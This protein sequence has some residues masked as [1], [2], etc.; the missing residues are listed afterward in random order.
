MLDNCP[1]NLD[2]NELWKFSSHQIQ[3][4]FVRQAI[5][6]GR[7]NREEDAIQ[8]ALTM[9]E[10]RKRWRFEILASVRKA[11]SSLARREG[12]LVTSHEQVTQLASDIKQRGM[13]KLAAEKSGQ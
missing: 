10:E 8:E 6:T 4:A 13:A 9:W 2:L 7:L 3:K 1:E 12:R 11:Q 5:E